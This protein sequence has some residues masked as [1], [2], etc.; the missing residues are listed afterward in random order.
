MSESQIVKI[1]KD[2]GTQVY[3][4][5]IFEI[6]KNSFFYRTPPAAASVLW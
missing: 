4:C 2:S 6:S 5:E 1:V 3:S